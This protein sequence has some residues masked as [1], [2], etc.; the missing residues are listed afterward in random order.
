MMSQKIGLVLDINVYVDGFVK[1]DKYAQ[2]CFKLIEQNSNFTLV[3]SRYT[4]EKTDELLRQ[5]LGHDPD[6]LAE[7][8]QKYDALLDDIE[9]RDRLDY[10]DTH[11]FPAAITIHNLDPEDSHIFKLAFRNKPSMIITS[12]HDF[13]YVKALKPVPGLFIYTP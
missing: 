12:D 3:V 6:L 13:D 8:F 10:S 7:V 9:A 11:P 4:T 1:N 2:A 5:K